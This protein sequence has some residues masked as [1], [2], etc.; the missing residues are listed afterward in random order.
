MEVTKS[1]GI[2]PD[3]GGGGGA[4][5]GGVAAPSA[6]GGD[7]QG[8]APAFD[9]EVSIL[10][11]PTEA[12][13]PEVQTAIDA[14]SGE[15]ARLR[16]ELDQSR[17]R[18][19]YLEK[20]ADMHP[21]LPVFNRRAFAR[22]LARTLVH[23]GA[24][25]TPVSLLC[26]H[27]TNADTVRRN[28]GRQAL[29]RGLAHVCRILEGAIHATDVVGNLGGADFG[30]VLLVADRDTALRKGAALVESVRAQ[31]I[32]WHDAELTLDL[33]WGARVLEPGAE[34]AEILDAADRQLLEM[35]RQDDRADAP[36]NAG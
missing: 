10:G 30:V 21:F 34:A 4:A 18:T 5:S 31:P 8:G 32:S 22:E 14:L 36:P 33:A 23:V 24:L 26:L 11:I 28:H 1:E 12:L 25:G 7:E 17:G 3:S 19:A 6:E 15:I 35:A 2:S 29:D 20:L 13:T 9:V 27:V 16:Q